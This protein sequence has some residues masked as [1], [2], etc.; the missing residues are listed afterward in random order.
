MVWVSTGS[1]WTSVFYLLALTLPV[2]QGPM[3]PGLIAES[4]WADPCLVCISAGTPGHGPS[5]AVIKFNFALH[6]GW[7]VLLYLRQ[8]VLTFFL[9]LREDFFHFEHSKMC[10]PP[11][12]MQMWWCVKF[13]ETTSVF[14]CICSAVFLEASCY[15]AFTA[16]PTECRCWC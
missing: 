13:K 5:L 2:S 11:P 1:R 10:P 7:L 16:S 12:V 3:C 9:F 15:N 6:K 14:S 4:T 8:Y